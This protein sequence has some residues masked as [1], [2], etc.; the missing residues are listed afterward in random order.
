MNI[1][2]V[3]P[4]EDNSFISTTIWARPEPNS[5]PIQYVYSHSYKL[6]HDPNKQGSWLAWNGGTLTEAIQ[7]IIN[8]K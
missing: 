7:H 3:I 2:S 4:N 6:I 1:V 5:L 8:L